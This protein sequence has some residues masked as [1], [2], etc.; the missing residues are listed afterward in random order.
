[1]ARLDAYIELLFKEP[2]SELV[3]ETGSGAVLRSASSSRPVLRQ[4]LSSAQ[5]VGAFSELVPPELKGSFPGQGTLKFRY[6]APAGDVSVRFESAPDRVSGWS[7][8][9]DRKSVV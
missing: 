4:S 9:R 2:G 7:R 6:A 3:M 8:S 5:I 1:M